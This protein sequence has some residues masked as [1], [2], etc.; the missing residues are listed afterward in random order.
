MN[1]RPPRRL[2]P[3][4]GLAAFEAVARL[5]SFTLAAEELYITRSAVSHRLRELEDRVGVQLIDRDA[6]P[7]SVTAAGA[8]YLATVRDALDAVAGA[9]QAM[10][11]GESRVVVAAPP[12]FA[13]EVLMP[14]LPAFRHAHPGVH[15]NVELAIPLRDVQPVGVDVEIR[16]GRGL[17]P[18]FVTLD[19]LDEPVFPVCS[20]QYAQ[21][22]ELRAP[23]DLARAVL[24]RSSLEPWAPWFAAASL[25]WPE[26]GTG[27]RYEDL[28]LLYQA[29]REGEGVA[30]ARPSFVHSLLDAGSVVRLFAVDARSP[31]AYYLV[32]RPS[33]LAR[34]EVVSFV[35]WLHGAVAQPA[36]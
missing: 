22:H 2:P 4:H 23:A 19:L 36:P 6:K 29:A 16:F 10:H 12:S 31:H 33:A 9:A 28:A 35:D 25:R 1:A 8:S 32:C 5:R 34:R 20:P 21:T 7:L 27:P 17:Y 30:L 14:R 3:L 24:L 11:V 18:E 15:V 26:P 13:R